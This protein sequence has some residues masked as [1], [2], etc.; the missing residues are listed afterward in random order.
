M[1]LTAL[2]AVNGSY[3]YVTVRV[4]LFGERKSITYEINLCEGWGREMA[5][6]EMLRSESGQRAR[7][8]D[9]GT[10]WTPVGGP[11]RM[12]R[13]KGGGCRVPH[14]VHMGKGTSVEPGAKLSTR[15]FCALID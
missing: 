14:A 11:A 9:A 4:V 6:T 2:V 8:K 12:S 5:D 13:V 10:A 3:R 15:P 7:A 1:K